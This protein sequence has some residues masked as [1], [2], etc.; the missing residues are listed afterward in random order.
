MSSIIVV[1]SHYSD[2]NDFRS[3]LT[4]KRI[5]DEERSISHMA[6]HGTAYVR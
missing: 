4:D 6:A 2:D 1:E 5:V 3:W